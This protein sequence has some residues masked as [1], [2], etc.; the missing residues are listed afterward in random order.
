ML[1]VFLKYPSVEVLS[2]DVPSLGWRRVVPGGGAKWD[3]SE[4]SAFCGLAGR[5][6]VVMAKVRRATMILDLESLQW[7]RGACFDCGPSLPVA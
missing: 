1:F 5:E 2:L 6:V 3:G 7:R 4:D